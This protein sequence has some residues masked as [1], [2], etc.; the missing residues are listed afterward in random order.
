VATTRSKSSF[1]PRHGKAVEPTWNKTQDGKQ[2]HPDESTKD[3]HENPPPEGQQPAAEVPPRSEDPT[4]QSTPPEA[5]ERS[6]SSELEQPTQESTA[7]TYTSSE[8]TLTDAP[9]AS[10][11]SEAATTTTATTE[12]SEAAE[13][14][15]QTAPT[16]DDSTAAPSLDAVLHMPSPDKVKHPHMTPPPYVHNFDSYSLVKQ[17]EEGGYTREQAITSMKAIRK[18]LAQNLDVAQKSLVSKSD[19]ENVGVPAKV[20][21]YVRDLTVLLGNVPFP[22]RVFRV[23]YGN[24]EQPATAGRANETAANTSPTRS[25][26]SYAVPQPGGVEFERCRPGPV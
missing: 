25:R 1:A 12:S 21:C 5:I 9:E 18:I 8:D 4:L 26:H 17:L 19:V 24:Q 11:A 7:T 14:P 23:G 20:P 6:E 13:E 15:G 22:S 3:V 16:S 10:E 2:P